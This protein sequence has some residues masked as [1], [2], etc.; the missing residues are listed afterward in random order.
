MWCAYDSLSLIAILCR[1]YNLAAH[2]HGFSD[3]GYARRGIS[4]REQNEARLHARVAQTLREKL[5]P[6]SLVEQLPLG[7]HSMKIPACRMFLR[8][9]HS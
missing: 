9:E 6:S 3:V 5:D 7:R 1:D 2:L 8:L 4:M